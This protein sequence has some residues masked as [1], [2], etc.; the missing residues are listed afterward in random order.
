MTNAYTINHFTAKTIN[1]DRQKPA[2]YEI[3]AERERQEELK[4]DGKF[5]FTCADDQLT[6]F[7]KLSILTEEVGEV[8]R[9]CNEGI[10]SNNLRNELAQVAAVAL[11]WMEALP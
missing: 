1:G 5:S 6:D 2:V 8:A 10:S 9:E 11:A 7:Q 4:A 3:L